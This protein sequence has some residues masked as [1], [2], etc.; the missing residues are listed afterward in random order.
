MGNATNWFIGIIFLLF[1]CSTPSE[2]PKATFVGK[3]VCKQCHW[4]HYESFMRSGMGQSFAKATRE[5]S[6]ATFAYHPVIYDST[7]KFYYHP[8]WEKDTLK[9]L[10][11]RLYEGETVYKRIETIH[12][13]IGSG[14]HT[15]SHLWQINGYLFQ[16]PIT[17]YTQK[18]LWDMAPGFEDYNVRF[19]RAIATECITCHNGYPQ[20]EP[21]SLNRYYAIPSGI[22]C[23]RCHG[24]GSLHVQ[25][26]QKGDKEA[27]KRWI[28]HPK[29]L[30]FQ[31]QMSLCMRC[32]LQGVAV[33]QPGK[34]FFD[35][36][37]GM[38][39]DSIL[40]VFVP[41]GQ[42]W[43]ASHVVRLM[44]SRCYQ[45]SQQLTCITCHSPHRSVKETPLRFY[46]S[47]CLQCHG[48]SHFRD[49]ACVVCHMPRSGSA[50]IPHV[51]ITD[52]KIQI[53][54][55]KR[56]ISEKEKEALRKFLGL[57]PVVLTSTTALMKAKAYLKYYESFLPQESVLDSA[58]YYLQ[59]SDEVP[60][61]VWVHYYFLRGAWE[62]VL[63][64]APDTS[65]IQDGWSAYR[66]G[67]SAS[68]LKKWH[69]A[70]RYWHKALQCMAFHPDFYSKIAGAYLALGK[71]QKA[72]YY[73]KKGIALHPKHAVLWND[74]GVYYMKKQQ[75][76]SALYC[77]ERSL[78]LDPD[79]WPAMYNKLQ[80]LLTQGQ[81][82]EVKYLL[83][84]YLYFNPGHVHAQRLLKVV[85][86]GF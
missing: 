3:Q 67:E 52:H 5:K 25:A 36:H 38:L 28:V 37:P 71:L 46:N 84:R 39:L 7:R 44:E 80:Y 15:N 21:Q 59:Q 31:Q 18:Q 50:D 79:Y 2:Q 17:F 20:W 55:K 65:V 75:Q 85:E 64:V 10:E 58:Y 51:A 19:S 86:V 61:E 48:D 4:S 16:A 35:F 81:I 49:S 54:S 63:S 66:I 6:A 53:P 1:A 12:Y 73:L 41:R 26:A 82:D 22:E 60:W 9:V 77:F 40:Q 74:L 29:R 83:K 32:H 42:F 23:E 14:H 24:N 69:L 72:Y 47:I 62:K 33:L 76:D 34:T 57:Q 78:S 45:Q 43:M 27:A 30:S 68:Q 8:F 70:L 11:F 56:Y 13:I